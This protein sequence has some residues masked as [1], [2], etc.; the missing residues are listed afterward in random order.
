M[1]ILPI[2][3]KDLFNSSIFS[4]KEVRIIKNKKNRTASTG[5]K[6]ITERLLEIKNK[7]KAKNTTERTITDFLK[8]AIIEKE[9]IK[10]FKKFI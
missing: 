3:S 7:Y 4:R 2:F 1:S 8:T 10:R 9:C 5:N 6:V